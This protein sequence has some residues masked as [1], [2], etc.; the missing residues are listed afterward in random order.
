VVLP[1]EAA[2]PFCAVALITMFATELFDTRVMWD[3]AAAAH[4]EGSSS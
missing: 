4:E 3:A 1:G 2:P